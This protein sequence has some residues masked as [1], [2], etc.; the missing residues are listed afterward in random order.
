MYCNLRVMKFRVIITI[1][2]LNASAPMD[3]T[4]QLTRLDTDHVLTIMN[5]NLGFMIVMIFVSIHLV[6]IF[7][8][9]VRLDTFGKMEFALMRMNATIH[10]V[11]FVETKLRVRTLMAV[12]NVFV[13]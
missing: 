10:I 13:H 2:L 12:M 9:R 3:S 8:I 5:V 4:I 1:A 6:R 7:V 11:I